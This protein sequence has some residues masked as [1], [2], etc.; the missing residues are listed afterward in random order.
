[1]RHRD[2]LDRTRRLLLKR[3]AAFAALLGA[4]SYAQALPGA[5]DADEAGL[6]PGPV[7]QSRAL[8]RAID[9]AAREGRPLTLGPGL[10]RAAGLS[11]PDGTVIV[12]AGEAT[13]L[14]LSGPGFLLS[15]KGAARIG[16]RGLL[17]DGSNYSAGAQTG[18][19]QASG[20][21]QLTL[22]EVAVVD[23]G[24]SAIALERT[25]G[26]IRAC[27]I[28]NA[29]QAAVFSMDGTGISVTDCQ[30]KACRNNA[31]VIR[32]TDKGDEPSIVSRN[33]IEDTGAIDGGLGWNGNGVNVSKA[34]GVI[35]SGNAIRRSAFTAVRAHQADD[36][37][38]SQNLC[39][40]CGEV[41]I[42]AEFGFSG[43]VVANNIV[44][45]SA[46]GI[47]VVN[48]NEGG[49]L[50][51]VTGN[52]VRNLFKRRHLDQPG[53]GYGLGISVEADVAVTGN[54]V[55]NAPVIGVLAG[56]GPFLRD[57]T[58]SGN[59][60]R[61]CGVGIGVSVVEGVGPAAVTGNVVTGSRQGAVRG[62]R[63]ADIST[64]DL[65]TGGSGGLP[66]LTVAQNIVR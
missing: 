65:A 53:E 32:R 60:V 55:E 16:L 18:V 62:Y 10:Y 66:G 26:A 38:I 4:P 46:S 20:V 34:G 49:R 45:G 58:I 61:G 1:M 33:R 22:D 42:F 44:D 19:V 30:I 12:G 21:G 43:A 7:E 29:R 51:S 39:L 25:G 13:R 5:L 9:R 17:L 35:V 6:R 14:E 24:D 23:A 64:P 27:R 11:L 50:A 8:Q 3:G 63:W 31:V 54:T 52:L 56:W 47:A 48:F 15:A 59:V 36:V 2:D 57:V 37:M 28:E 40:D 41:A